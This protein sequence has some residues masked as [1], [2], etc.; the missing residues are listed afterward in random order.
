MTVIVNDIGKI[1]FYNFQTIPIYQAILSAFYVQN[2]NKL[3][4][5]IKIHFRAT[6][7][8]EVLKYRKKMI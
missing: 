8:K 7:K 1:I 6:R 4:R 3:K 2:M 5:I